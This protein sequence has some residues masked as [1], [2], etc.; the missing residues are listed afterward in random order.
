MWAVV[1]SGELSDRDP[2]ISSSAHWDAAAA[3]DHRR[4]GAVEDSPGGG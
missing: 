2:R 4:Q 1:V 3:G